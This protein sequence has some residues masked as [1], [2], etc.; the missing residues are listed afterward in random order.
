MDKIN[1]SHKPDYAFLLISRN[2]SNSVFKTIQSILRL[3]D[4]RN[5]EVVL[6]DDHSD[7]DTAQVAKPLCDKVLINKTRMGIAYSR[8]IGLETVRANKVFI[9]DSDIEITKIDYEEI[10]KLFSQGVAAISGNYYSIDK[11]A[12]WNRALDLRRKYIY[13]KNKK[14]LVS[15]GNSYVPL[16]GGFCV[17]DRAK[18]DHVKYFGKV[19]VSAE[20]ILFQLKLFSLGLKTAYSPTLVGIHHHHRNTRGFFSKVWAD[21]V[22]YPWLI[23]LCLKNNLKTPIIEQAFNFPLFL[24]LSLFIPGAWNKTILV[25][26][27]FFPQIYVVI[28]DKFSNNSLRLLIY[29]ISGSLIKIYACFVYFISRKYNLGERYRYVRH[30][31]TSDFVSKYQWFKGLLISW[32]E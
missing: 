30:I 5:I 2:A 18:V 20:D 24:A 16:S 17:V 29:A 28:V 6:V 25:A 27:E 14:T 13:H 3:S 10:D 31:V 4:K 12:G 19:N 11:K 7:D 8:Q 32:K 21:S 15:D 22:A 9:I 26:L 23:L 1:H